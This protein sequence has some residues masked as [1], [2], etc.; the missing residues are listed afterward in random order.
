M[1]NKKDVDNI[2][3]GEVLSA[4]IKHNVFFLKI[5]TNARFKFEKVTLSDTYQCIKSLKNTNSAGADNI[6]SKILKESINE[7][8]HYI[9]DLINTSFE[10]VTFPKASK[11]CKI[12]P[13]YK[14]GDVSD[15][16]NFR[17]ISVS[18]VIISKRQYAF[19][20]NSNINTTLFD[21]I[22][23][24]EQQ[25]CEKKKIGVMFFDMNQNDD[26]NNM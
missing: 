24:I 14:K 17:P 15:I 4:K 1:P 16:D 18:S 23:Y 7:L 26:F 22:S 11:N 2:T 5:E 25:I 20:E 10:L 19:R 8:V 13:I 21:V 12:V 3:I 6:N 9:R